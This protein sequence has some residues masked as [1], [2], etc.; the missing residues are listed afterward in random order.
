VSAARR[1]RRA[2]RLA[3][4]GLAWA[5]ALDAT[6]GCGPAPETVTRFVA[7]IIQHETCVKSGDRPIACTREERQEERRGVLVEVEDENVWLGDVTF[8]NNDAATLLGTRDAA[9]GFLF[10][11]ERA[12]LDDLSGCALR[13]RTTLSLRIAD[14]EAAGLTCKALVGRELIETRTTAACD[15]VHAPPEAA[16][17]ENR[18]RWEKPP[19]CDFADDDGA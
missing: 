17:R 1:R 10:V 6:A 19:T 11:A 3:G 9:G 2:A 13:T 15:A 16:V 14:H 8:G 12:R 4:A 7:Q 18:R 5:A